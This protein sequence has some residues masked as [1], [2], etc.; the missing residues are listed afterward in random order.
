MALGRLVPRLLPLGPPCTVPFAVLAPALS[1]EVT[2]HAWSGS[3]VS[4]DGCFC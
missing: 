2:L 3:L 4:K 1:C